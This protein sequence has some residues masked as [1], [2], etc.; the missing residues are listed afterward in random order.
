VDYAKTNGVHLSLYHDKPSSA[1]KAQIFSK[2]DVLAKLK[3]LDGRARKKGL[4]SLTPSRDILVPIGMEISP[5]GEVTK[6][7]YGV[8]NLAW[9]SEEHPE[10]PGKV[11]KELAE[12]R[13]R[14]RE[15]HG[16]KIKYV[17]WAGM[18]GSAE[19][20]TMYQAVGLLRKGPKVFV[21]DSTDPCKL[22]AI[23]DALQARNASLEEAL[24]STLVVGMAMGMTSYEPVVNL[25]HLA[26]L[27]AKLGIDSRPNIVYMTLPGSIL[28]EFG[29]SQ[30]YRKIELQLDEGN[31]TA[32]RHSAPMTRGSLYPL[33]LCGVD[34]EEWI[35]KAQL[36]E[37]QIETAFTLA[38]FLQEQAR[39]GRNKITLLLPK[40]WAGAGLWTKQDFEESLGKSEE[41]GLKVVIGERI[42]LANYHPPKSSDQDRCFLAVQVKGHAGEESAKASA[43]RRAGYPV[44]LLQL[45]EPS[46]SAYMQFMHYVVFG[47]GYLEKMNFVTQ[48]SVELYKAVTSRLMQ[49]A[50]GKSGLAN[51]SA[52][53]SFAAKETRYKYRDGVTLCVDRLPESMKPSGGNAVQIYARLLKETQSSGAVEYGELTYFG[54][55]RYNRDGRALR[56][57]LD[58]AGDR[59]FRSRLKM[60]VDIYE[61][62]AM[63]HSYHEMIIGH[64]RCF[65]T[66]LLSESTERV[67]HVDATPEYHRAQFLATQIALAERGRLVVSI[68]LKDLKATTR[69]TLDE[70]FKAVAAE[71]RN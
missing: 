71:L 13:E 33:G 44:A 53:T 68:S 45:K 35:D 39:A 27:Y 5:S 65:S 31:S 4:G 43:L 7:S 17:I 50:E 52:W 11:A 51:T 30:G 1:E 49:E 47:I 26:A 14:I 42:K 62:P 46:L 22:K 2:Q 20:K 63:N 6:N 61:G 37:Q 34:L 60:P 24:K 32:G 69:A 56:A 48:P 25:R 59:V 18:G 54:D 16:A 12:L 66:V 9:Q 23:L 10:W 70:F 8:F 58:R 3:A 15:A 57:T 21:L 38:A 67:E 28:D 29:K 41:F 36:S 19:D 55:M 64:G 40:A